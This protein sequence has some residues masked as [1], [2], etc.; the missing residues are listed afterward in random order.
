MKNINKRLITDEIKVLQ[1]NIK[2]AENLPQSN[3]ALLLIEVMKTVK[4]RIVDEKA[5]PRIRDLLIVSLP[6]LY[7]QIWNLKKL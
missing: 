3:N 1:E 7:I 5:N 6:L 2:V 4:K